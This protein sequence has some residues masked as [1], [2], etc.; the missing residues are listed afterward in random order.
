MDNSFKSLNLSSNIKEIVKAP[1]WPD[2][3]DD[4]PNL[5]LDILNE[6]LMAKPA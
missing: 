4:Y 1:D 3:V 2:F 6:I 5:V